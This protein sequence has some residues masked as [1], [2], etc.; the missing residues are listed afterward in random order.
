M[1]TWAYVSSYFFHMHLKYCFQMQQQLQYKN[2]PIPFQTYRPAV[3]P[4]D[5]NNKINLN[6][7]LR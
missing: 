4:I 5:V 1:F 6:E 2:F 7:N 3:G